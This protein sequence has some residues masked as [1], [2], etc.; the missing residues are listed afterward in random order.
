M[1]NEILLSLRGASLMTILETFAEFSAQVQYPNISHIEKEIIALHL[2]DT[3]GAAIAGSKTPNGIA[4]RDLYQPVGRDVTICRRGTIDDIVVRTGT[5]RHTEIDDIHT[6]SNVTPS[7]IIVPTTLTMC[8]RLGISDPKLVGS[9]LISGYEALLRLGMVIDGP[10]VMYR[11]IWP[12]FFCAPFGA[13][14]A[15]ARLLNLSAAETAHALANALTL[16]TGGAG[17]AGPNRPGRWFII[18]A[19]AR[20]G[21]NSALAAAHGFTAEISLLDRDWLGQAHGLCGKPEALTNGLG[22]DGIVKDISMKPCCTGKQVAAALSAFQEILVKGLNPDAAIKIEVFVPQR[23]AAMVDR[24]VMPG[25]NRSTTGNTRYQF[26][27]AAYHPEILFDAARLEPIKDKRLNALMEKV[28]IT[29]DESLEKYMP[30]H[31][32]ARV[33]VTTSDRKFVETVVAA[34]GDPDRRLSEASVRKKFHTLTDGL[35]GKENAEAW[36][37]VCSAALSN[38]TGTEALISRFEKLFNAEYLP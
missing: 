33:E 1:G 8:A 19:A 7:S 13:A 23:Y 27:L 35:I 15:T 38:N 12:T 3:M 37:A 36:I 5:I 34:P 14:A 18:G 31:W 26:G 10:V 4:L 21:V 30:R 6:R 17:N 25:T 24:R 11:G 20:A 22:A 9:A 16:C 2:L 28:A 29:V 32:P